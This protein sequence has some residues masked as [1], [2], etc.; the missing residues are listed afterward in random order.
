MVRSNG[1]FLKAVKAV[2][3]AA[4]TLVLGGVLPG[5]TSPNDGYGAEYGEDI[6]GDWTRYSRVT[7][8][9][10][11]PDG[12]IRYYNDLN[13]DEKRFM[14]F[15]PSGEAAQW[16]FEKVG[17]VWV[18]MPFDGGAVV[19][20]RVEDQIIYISE[21]RHEDEE[22]YGTYIISGNRLA[23]T[24]C[25]YEENIEENGNVRQVHYCSE[26]TFTR[27]DVNNIRA[28]LGTVYVNDSRI[29]KS[30]TSN[31]LL[32]Y[33]PSDEDEYIDFDAVRVYGP[34]LDR[35]MDEHN[36]VAYYTN[37]N[38][39]YLV[40]QD[41]TWDEDYDV[42]QCT[43]SAPVVL[44]YDIIGSGNRARLSING[45]TWWPA[46]YHDYMDSHR[47]SYSPAKSRQN[48]RLSALNTG[49]GIFS[50]KQK[51]RHSL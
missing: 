40:S 19:R 35:Y 8:S 9:D 42:S 39:I 32:W 37:G 41:C 12:N 38:K 26:E 3:A 18:E 23:V 13:S 17:N 6:V 22:A 7:S 14:S 11:V 47:N 28:G 20:W 49:G 51:R 33:S 48:K 50:D 27:V 34:G 4:V 30:A 46:D 43:A 1:R 21:P 45:D 29:Y 25:H 44:N 15:R 24:R 2:S 31:D 5:C 16:G 10:G 36:S